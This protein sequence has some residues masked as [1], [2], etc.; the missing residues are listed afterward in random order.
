[1]ILLQNIKT[2]KNS[3]MEQQLGALHKGFMYR[4]ST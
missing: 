4:D 1:M 2:F 3:K